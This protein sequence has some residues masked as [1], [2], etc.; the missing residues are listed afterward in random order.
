M[1]DALNQKLAGSVKSKTMIANGSGI[2]SLIAF[3]NDP[4]LAMLPEKAKY[5]ILGV[6]AA[7]MILRWI[8]DKS[9]AQKGE[10]KAKPIDDDSKKEIV[11][12]VTKLVGISLPEIIDLKK[13][14]GAMR[15]EIEAYKQFKKEHPDRDYQEVS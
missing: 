7:N 13:K 14:I 6:L 15:Y 8:T 3:W 12:E 4:M 10:K 11:N 9:L 2:A 5:I 1:S